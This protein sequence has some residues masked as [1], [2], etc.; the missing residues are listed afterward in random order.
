MA[1]EDTKHLF[2]LSFPT[3]EQADAAV[4]ELHELERDQFIEVKDYALVTKG[5]MAGKIKAAVDTPTR[6]RAEAW[7][8]AVSPAG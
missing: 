1:N 7:S 4:T 5:E 2:V 3:R 6:A 8:R